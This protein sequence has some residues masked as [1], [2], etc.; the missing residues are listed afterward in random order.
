[1]THSADWSV[2]TTTGAERVRTRPKSTA[3]GRSCARTS[4]AAG[5]SECVRTHCMDDE[6]ESP[7]GVETAFGRQQSWTAEA[8]F[9]LAA[10]GIAPPIGHGVP[11]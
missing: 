1:M 4:E 7:F 8:A 6:M 11:S 10:R 3:V 5:E 9:A 2:G